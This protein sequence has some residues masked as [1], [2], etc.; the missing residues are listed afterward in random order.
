[1]REIL[2]YL[3]VTTFLFTMFPKSLQVSKELETGCD[4]DKD[5]GFPV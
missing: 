5:L 2:W 4:E 1:M 3:T